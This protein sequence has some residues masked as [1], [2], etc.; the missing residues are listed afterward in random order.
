MIVLIIDIEKLAF[1]FFS[2]LFQF[3]YEMQEN[4]KTFTIITIILLYHLL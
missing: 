4:Y 2:F 1:L 3:A